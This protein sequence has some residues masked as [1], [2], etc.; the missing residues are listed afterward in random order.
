MS[1]SIS[2]GLTENTF[3]LTAIDIEDKRHFPKG[4]EFALSPMVP[5]VRRRIFNLLKSSF[6]SLS[7]SKK[8][9]F[10]K[11]QIDLSNISEPLSQLIAYMEEKGLL[12]RLLANVVCP[13]NVREC[14]KDINEMQGFFNRNLTLE[15]EIKI[16][17]DFFSSPWAVEILR[18][19]RSI[20]RILKTQTPFL[21]KT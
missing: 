2:R 21:D 9:Q 3:I 15:Q 19:V 1:N 4:R 14:D 11:T 18:T 10:Y 16:F 5:I 13:V 12:E 8:S 7:E 6:D 20:L 17:W